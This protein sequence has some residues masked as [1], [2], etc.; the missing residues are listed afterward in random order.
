VRLIL[1]SNSPRRRELLHSIGL[2]V[3]V[4]PSHVPEVR[5]DDESPSSYVR[6]L[7]EEKG[8]EIGRRIPD[9]WVVSADT[10]V[11]IGEMLLEKPVDRSDAERMLR[12]ISGRTHVVHTGVALQRFRGDGT[13]DYREIDLATSRVTMTA[14]TDEDIRWYAGTGEPLDKAGAYAAQGIGAL[15]I[16]AIDGSYTNVVGLPL[17]TLFR[18]LRRAGLD[19][20]TMSQGG[21]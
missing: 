13:V 17:A 16:E 12:E 11:V 20:L 14:L 21:S 15:F 9:R 4:L 1:A 5:R 7:A 2:E 10:T 18:M 8:A 19:P 3:D 6:R